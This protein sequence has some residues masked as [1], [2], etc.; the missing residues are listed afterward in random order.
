MAVKQSQHKTTPA[1]LWAEMLLALPKKGGGGGGWVSVGGTILY[2]NACRH[3]AQAP[4][5]NPSRACHRCDTV[6]QFVPIA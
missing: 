3:L 5:R 2:R 4:D 1:R 6:D